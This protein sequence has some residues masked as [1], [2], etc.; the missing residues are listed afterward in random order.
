MQK[1]KSVA[2]VDSKKDLLG[3]NSLLWPKDFQ[4]GSNKSHIRKALSLSIYKA[5]KKGHVIITFSSAG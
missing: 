1:P 4:W 5:K 2:R 3:A